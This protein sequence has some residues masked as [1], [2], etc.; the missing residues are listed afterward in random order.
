LNIL[1]LTGYGVKV[2]V[3]NLKSRSELQ[4]TDGRDTY[5]DKQET[6]SFPPRKIP[7]NSLIIDG[8]SG[9]ISLQAFHWLSKNN[10]PVFIMDFDGTIISSILPPAPVKTDVKVAQIGAA[11]NEQTRVKVAYALTKAKLERSLTVLQWIADRYDI[12]TQLRAVKGETINLFKAKTVSQIRTVEGRVA[13][14]YWQAFQSI[15]PECFT[16]EG[17]T[18]G[19]HNNNATD[20]VNLALNYG[21]GVLEGE[22]RK[23]INT[24]GLE[25][26]IGFLHDYSDYQTKQSLVY[27]LQEPFRWLVDVTVLKAIESGVLDLKDFYFLG[28]D[29][30][31]HFDLPAKRRFLNLLQEQFNIGIKY[32]VGTQKWNTIILRKTQE[33]AKYLTGKTKTIDF[34]EPTPT[35][36]RTDSQELRNR[37]LKISQSEAKD[38]GI[39]KSTLHYLRKHA[40]ENK[41]FKV[42]SKV[43]KKITL[44]KPEKVSNSI[45]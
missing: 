27:D 42:Y 14:R 38:I 32:K 30:R 7:Y 9:Y 22:C 36:E 18:T 26:S 41:A 29:Y 4:I 34:T 11:S 16:F 1:Q 44:A 24:V 3:K 37:I 39:G 40:R 35:L 17:R 28:N 45:T 23:A 10:I 12:T 20:P 33:L 19:K 25:P 31:Y 6:F 15:I 13:L 43:T 8:H 5:K 2:K 21:Y